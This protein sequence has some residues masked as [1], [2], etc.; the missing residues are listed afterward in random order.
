MRYRST[1]TCECF[2]DA[3]AII[4]PKLFINSYFEKCPIVMVLEEYFALSFIRMA[5][6]FLEQR[7]HV[8]VFVHQ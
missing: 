2:A 8:L 4:L 5:D 3:G 1:C 6:V 7:P